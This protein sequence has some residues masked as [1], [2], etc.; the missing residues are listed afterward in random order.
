MFLACTQGVFDIPN[1]LMNTTPPPE[2]HGHGARDERMRIWSL[3]TNSASTREM[4]GV[5]SRVKDIVI[6]LSLEACGLFR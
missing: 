4:R 1:R 3:Y 2:G 5:L 6:K